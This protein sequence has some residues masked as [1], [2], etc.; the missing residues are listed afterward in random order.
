MAG[1]QRNSTG[2]ILRAHGFWMMALS[3]LLTLSGCHDSD[4]GSAAPPAAV[5]PTISAQPLDQTVT[6]GAAVNFSVTAAGTAPLTYQWRRDAVAISGATSSSYALASTVTSDS[7]AKFSVVVTNA[8]GS[9][10]SAA[11]TLTVTAPGQLVHAASGGQVSSSDGKLRVT[12][13]ANA[14]SGDTTF[15]IT[16]LTTIS[17]LPAN[18]ALVSGTAYEID[19]S[20][21]GFIGQSTVT[22][23]F[24]DPNA[25]QGQKIHM[26]LR[27][28]QPQSDPTPI[29]S[30]VVQ[31]GDGTQVYATSTDPQ[32][33]DYSDTTA[34]VCSP[35][36]QVGLVQGDA[37]VVL[38]SI[39]TQPANAS[40]TVGDTA[41][42]SV[43]ATGTAP[44]FFQWSRNGVA[45][46]NATNSS[47]S[48]VTA[49]ADNGAKFSVTVSSAFGR[50]VSA[51][52]TL[53]VGPP[54]PPPAPTWNPSNSL[55]SPSALG[56]GLPQAGNMVDTSF[57]VWNNNGVLAANGIV[58]A[59]NQPVP[60]LAPAI[61]LTPKVLT[62]PNF[63]ISYI[64]FVDDDG[65]QCPSR[66]MGDRL[67]AVAWG[68]TDEVGFYTPSAPFTLYRS[69]TDCIADFSAG[70]SP[71]I[72]AQIPSVA[73]AAQVIDSQTVFLGVNGASHPGTVVNGVA[74]T[75]WTPTS[76]A[77]ASLMTSTDCSNPPVGTLS[78]DGMMGIFQAPSPSLPSSSVATLAFVGG[79]PASVCAATFSGTA[80]STAIKVF[81]NADD[82]EPAVAVDSHGN[83]LLFGSRIADIN[84]S[85][86]SYQ[87][88]ANY[89]AAGASSWQSQPLDS[90]NGPALP[91]VAFDSNGN[92]FAVWR[93]ALSANSIVYGAHLSGV[94]GS[95]D[96]VQ[97]LSA[98]DAL[99]TRYPRVCVDPSG[100]AVLLFEQN[101]ATFQGSTDPAS[102]R[103][104]S[105]Y[106]KRGLWSDI[107]PVQTGNNDGRFADC[108]RNAN[109][110]NLEITW[111]ETDAADA[112]SPSSPQHYTVVTDT[113]NVP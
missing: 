54:V 39:T 60:T 38:P 5:A 94:D 106:W 22:L 32:A 20:G 98:A 33:S 11:A 45:I 113:L 71:D 76:N 50:V 34:V 62:G 44:L 1:I 51:Q 3:A 53:T 109:L 47:Y 46:A 40:V 37:D 104:F 48:L 61:Y 77:A 31:C 63:S 95:W 81:D 86:R 26:T 88:M 83:S 70:M 14:L 72:A 111:R 102:Y 6:A 69:A 110:S 80:W 85:V 42:F 65:S 28:V 107:S 23:S 99:D 55:T 101:Y 43:A 58:G 68:F 12:I 79:S 74:S 93:P 7:G 100:T 10:T 49:A 29:S 84:A 19:I 96:A 92:A 35:T 97:S 67:S 73:F 82:A 59:N 17:N 4:G 78:L 18:Y 52:A 108:A 66:G 8:A 27:G 57:V 87:M 16:P 25:A 21:A 75:T 90:R 36:T 13:A 41:T 15:N 9:I 89:L 56:V 91:S 24:A 64:V 112:R 103:V 30:A 105:R 2:T